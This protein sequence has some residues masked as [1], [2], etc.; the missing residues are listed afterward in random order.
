MGKTS[1]PPEHVHELLRYD[2]NS[3]NLYWRIGVRSYGGGRSAGDVAGTNKDGYISICLDG[4]RYRAHR[5]VWYIVT[6]DWLPA[7]QDIDHIN[8]NRGD[9]RFSN[10]RLTTRSQNNMNL[11]LRVDNISG[12]R[13]VTWRKDTKKWHA[14]ITVNSKITILGDFIDLEDARAARAKAEELYFGVHS[15]LNRPTAV[16]TTTSAES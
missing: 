5:L 6:G 4:V 7:K 9:N 16:A 8:G 13:G 1:K 12:Y 11:P 14:R 2:P 15:Y 10:L 3:G